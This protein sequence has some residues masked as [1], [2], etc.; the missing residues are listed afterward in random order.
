M[1]END[2]GATRAFL[3]ATEGHLVSGG[4]LH[5]YAEG[6]MWEYYAPVRPFKKGAATLA[7]RNG[8]PL[9][10]LAFSYRAPGK[11]RRLFGQIATFTLHIGEPL[12]ADGSLPERERA[13][14]LTRRAH[15]AVCRLAGLDES[16]DIYPPVFDG[17]ARRIDYYTGTYGVGYKGSH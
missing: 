9:M 2:M 13:E 17:T 12:F 14:D 16:T 3:K 11:L 10:P 7:V 5:I 15:E 8:K 1:P 4:W 6:S